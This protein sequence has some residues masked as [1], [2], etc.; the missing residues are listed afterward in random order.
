MTATAAAART[1]DRLPRGYWRLWSATIASGVGNGASAAALPLLAVSLTRDPRLIAAVS[2]AAYLPWLLFSLVA[3][4]LADRI[5]RRRLMWVAQLVQAAVVAVVGVAAGAHFARVWLLCAAALVLGTA[6]TVFDNAG[7]SVLP[8]IVTGGQLQRA[9]AAQYAGQTVTEQFV[10]PPVGSLLFAVSVGL[11]FGLDAVSFLVSAALIVRLALR[12][13]F[14][15][16]ALPRTTS[17]RAEIGEGLR[18]LW[19]HRLLR[20]LALLLGVNNFCNQLVWATLVLLATDTFGLSARA[21]GLLL[22]GQAVGG[23]LGSV[24]NRPLVRALGSRAALVAALCTTALAYLGAGLAPDAVLVGALLA[25][26]GVASMV[27]NVVTVSLRQ[28]VVPAGL[29]GRVNSAYRM[30]GWGMIPLGAAA[31]GLVANWLGLRAPLLV[32]GGLRLVTLA[33][34]IPV[35]VAA[36]RHLGGRATD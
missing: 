33:A 15:A 13:Q 22:A 12:P 36:G 28:D 20:G 9:N 31:G 19:S 30:L 7:Q 16:T 4:A 17:L 35:L 18:W 6:E 21:Y 24:V 5:D 10:G 32:A 8:Q 27:W 2:T 26:S 11:P 1:A 34:A 23:V 3:G 25:L 14:P 29:L